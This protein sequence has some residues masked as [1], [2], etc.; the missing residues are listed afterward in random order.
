MIV[1]LFT[2]PVVAFLMSREVILDKIN[3]ELKL[4]CASNAKGA[5]GEHRIISCAERFHGRQAY[6]AS[7]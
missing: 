7:E 4:K 1:G 6:S 3:K 5:S 2:L